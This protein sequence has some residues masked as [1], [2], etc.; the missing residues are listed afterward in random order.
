MGRFGT[1][2]LDTLGNLIDG[3]GA[4]HDVKGNNVVSHGTN[5]L[6]GGVRYRRPSNRGEHP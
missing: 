3:G 1:Q 6:L 4:A 5:L 2:G